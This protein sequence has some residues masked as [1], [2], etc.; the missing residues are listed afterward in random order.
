MD[1]LI[2]AVEK[3]LDETARSCLRLIGTRS[4]KREQHRALAKWMFG[5]L[6]QR[7]TIR[8]RIARRGVG[9]LTKVMTFVARACEVL[10][11]IDVET[12]DRE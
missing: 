8:G 11:E 12:S 2:G 10:L 4:L 7:Y 6:N 3:A 5:C 1:D 9:E